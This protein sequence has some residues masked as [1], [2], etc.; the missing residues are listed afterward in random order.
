[1]ARDPEAI[2]REI[3]QAREALGG[4]L[5]QLV[6]RANPKRLVEGGKEKVRAKLA[7][8]KVRY[9]LIGVGAVVA[10]LVVRRLVRR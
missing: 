10:L 6:E 9:A 1:V 5:D 2:E 7:E 8:P 3:E 4:T